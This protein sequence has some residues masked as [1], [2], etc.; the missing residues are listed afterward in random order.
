M[1]PCVVTKKCG[2][3]ESG[4]KFVE[5]QKSEKKVIGFTRL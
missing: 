1:E 5:L 4:N 2:A 3:F